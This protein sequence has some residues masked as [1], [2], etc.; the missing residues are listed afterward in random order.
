MKAPFIYTLLLLF[1]CHITLGQGSMVLTDNID[2]TKQEVIKFGSYIHL[3][4]DT[5][6]L[7]VDSAEKYV[8]LYGQVKEVTDSSIT[9]VVQYEDIRIERKDGYTS[10]ISNRYEEDK[11]TRTIHVREIYELT[12]TSKRRLT[13]NTIVGSI[14]VTSILGALFVA[15]LVS[16]DYKNGGFKGKQY[17]ILLGSGAMGG[18]VFMP[19]A[20]KIARKSEFLIVHDVSNRDY[21]IG[22]TISKGK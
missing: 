8:N 19:I 6:R 3:T 10:S 17:L 11:E 4:L 18:L 14:G 16:I 1:C 2:T 9:I 12:H 5:Q 7:G 20:L 22:W 13:L 15:P 21:D